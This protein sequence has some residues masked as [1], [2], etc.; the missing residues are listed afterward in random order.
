M[1]NNQNN[2]DES[3]HDRLPLLEGD[4]GNRPNT[5]EDDK[6]IQKYIFII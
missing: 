2:N 6:E 4:H 3:N 5:T 1:E